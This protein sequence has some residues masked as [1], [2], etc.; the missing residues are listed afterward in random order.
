DERAL[1]IPPGRAYAEKFDPRLFCFRGHEAAA[2][3]AGASVVAHLGWAPGKKLAPPYVVRPI[4]GLEPKVAAAKELASA[5]A[6][7]GPSTSTAKEPDGS[8]PLSVRTPQA[9]DVSRPID[10]TLPV[11]VVNTSAS[12]ATFLLRPTTIALDVNGP[13]GIGVTDPSPSIRC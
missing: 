12:S 8:R 10:I 6:A 2:L 1:V 9:I 4:D 11:T 5:S 7:V 3:V 13:S